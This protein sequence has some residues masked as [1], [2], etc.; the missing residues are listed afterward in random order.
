MGSQL[1]IECGLIYIVILI[2]MT[3]HGG[4]PEKES[5]VLSLGAVGVL[6]TPR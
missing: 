3:R 5:P 2:D 1:E 4:M 6:S